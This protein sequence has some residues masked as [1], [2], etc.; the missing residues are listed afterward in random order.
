MNSENSVSRICP[1]RLLTLTLSHTTL[2]TSAMLIRLAS[3]IL[4]TFLLAFPLF[5]IPVGGII[6]DQDKQLILIA[7]T[8]ILFILWFFTLVQK[9][10]FDIV[11]SQFDFVFLSFC[12]VVIASLLF[13]S[14]NKIEGLTSTMGVSTIITVSLLFFLLNQFSVFLSPHSIFTS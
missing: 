4:F 7:F 2:R 14:P 12:L 5:A 11:R 9:K 6:A 13:S 3:G 1:I 8:S 10:R